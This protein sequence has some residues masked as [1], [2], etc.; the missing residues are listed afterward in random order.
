[1]LIYYS[2]YLADIAVMFGQNGSESPRATLAVGVE[3]QPRPLPA[4]DLDRLPVVERDRHVVGVAWQATAGG[5]TPSF[6]P[7]TLLCIPLRKD[8]Q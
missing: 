4:Q 1:M 6:R 2:R 7:K 3:H 8:C 5:V